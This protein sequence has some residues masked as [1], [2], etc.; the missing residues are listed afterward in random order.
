MIKSGLSEE[1]YVMI[2]ATVGWS[3]MMSRA[4]VGLGAECGISGLLKWCG[5]SIGWTEYER[6]Y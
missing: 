3:T 1:E 6:S 2:L 4:G 5:G